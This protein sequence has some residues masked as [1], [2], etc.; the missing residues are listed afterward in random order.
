MRYVLLATI[1]LV[2]NSSFVG[3]AK[4]GEERSFG[5]VARRGRS[6]AQTASGSPIFRW[7]T[8]R[9]PCRKRVPLDRTMPRSPAGKR[10]GSRRRTNRNQ[11]RRATGDCFA[12]S[13]HPAPYAQAAMRVGRSRKKGSVW[14]SPRSCANRV[15]ANTE[16]HAICRMWRESNGRVRCPA[17]FEQNPKLEVVVLPGTTGNN[18]CK[19]GCAA[20]PRARLRQLPGARSFARAVGR[21]M[22]ATA[23]DSAA[24]GICPRTRSNRRLTER[25]RCW[26]CKGSRRR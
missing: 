16:A 14:P 25:A 8:H 13:S 10:A 7:P 22:A 20:R 5:A 15:C 21:A 17:T 23:G 3:G 11:T 1:L 12:G 26:P 4:S 9:Q 24:I 6:E 18:R 19:F 2:A